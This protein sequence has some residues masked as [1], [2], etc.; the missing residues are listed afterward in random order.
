[1]TVS[2]QSPCSAS[3]IIQHGIKNW[4]V[5]ECGPSNFIWEYEEKEICLI[6]E[7][8]ATIKTLK[9]EIYNI[10]SGDLVQFPKG[11]SCKWTITKVLKNTIN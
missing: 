1:M 3:F 9:G 10:K 4:P 8:K 11:F 5:W 2:I 6:I 7:G